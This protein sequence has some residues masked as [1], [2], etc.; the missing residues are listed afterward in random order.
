MNQFFQDVWRGLNATPKYLESKYF[1]DEKG[2]KLFQ[3]I[4]DCPEYYLTRCELEIF[5]KQ[6]SHLADSI[7][8]SMKNFDVVELGAGDATKSSYLLQHLLERGVDFTYYP[9]D[10]SSNV[11][12]NLHKQLPQ[13]MPGLQIRG[14]NGEYFSMLEEVKSISNRNKVVLFLGSSIGNI[15]FEQTRGFLNC[16]TEHLIPGDLM[17]IGFDLKKDPVTILAA[18]NDKGGI[19]REF[20][21]NLLRRINKEL[22]ADFDPEL[23]EHCPVYDE[24]MGAC[25]SYL[26][27]VKQQRVRIGEVGWVHF[28]E[29]ETIF[30][31]ISQKYTVEQINELA[32]DAGFKP[33]QYFYDSQ[34]RF[35]D[36]IWQ[37]ENNG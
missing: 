21:L 28:E 16:L 31:E 4:M 3:E 20:N 19:T 34:N 1:Y 14:L 17:L 36:A 27:S 2:D 25:R 6:T 26:K 8:H 15:P 13:R 32:A 7:L 12:S 11:I 10:I 23:F 37:L 35:L 30:M 29:G 33:V 5:S 18:Y 9:I 22:D 24:T